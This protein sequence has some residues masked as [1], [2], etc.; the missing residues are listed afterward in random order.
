[1]SVLFYCTKDEGSRDAVYVARL[2]P[3]RVRASP[4]SVARVISGNIVSRL[5]LLHDCRDICVHVSVRND[6]FILISS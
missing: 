4:L 6:T 1:M 2:S 5:W 3:F